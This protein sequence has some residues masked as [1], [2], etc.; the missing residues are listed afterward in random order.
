MFFRSLLGCLLTSCGL[1]A[2]RYAWVGLEEIK[3][4]QGMQMGAASN[5]PLFVMVIIKPL[6]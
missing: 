4:D 6:R 1:L 3:K 2:V 5:C